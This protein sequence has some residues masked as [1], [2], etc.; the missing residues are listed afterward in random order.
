[1]IVDLM[2]LEREFEDLAGGTRSVVCG[3]ATGRINS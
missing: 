1:M 3:E 2:V